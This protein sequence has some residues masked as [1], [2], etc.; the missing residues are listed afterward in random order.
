MTLRRFLFGLAALSVGVLLGLP[1]AA[2]LRPDAPPRSTE[3]ITPASVPL[4]AA[5]VE[6][7]GTD[8]PIEPVADVPD[9]ISLNRLLREVA[10]RVTPAVVFLRVDVTTTTAALEGFQDEFSPYYGARNTTGSGIIIS[11]SGYV[12]TNAHVVEGATRVRVALYDKR[13]YEAEIQGIDASTDLAVLRLLGVGADG[14]TEP[15]PVAT[16]GDSDAVAPGD[17]VLTVGSPL[18]LSNTVTFGIVS[19]T[20]RRIYEFEGSGGQFQIQDF[21][22]TDAAINPG[23]SG[24]ALVNVRG[25]VVG[26]VTSIATE[27]GFNEGYGFAVPSNLARRVAQ[28]LVSTG[29]VRRGFL[30]VEVQE[31][32][33]DVARTQGMRRAQGVQI[34]SVF[35]G[36]SGARAGLRAGDVLLAVDGRPV[37]SSNEFQSRL[38]LRRPGETVTLTVWR[39]GETETVRAALISQDDPSFR[40]WIAGREAP[41]PAG[42]EPPAAVPPDVP[43][44]EAVDWGIRF[45]DLTSRERRDFR[46]ASGAFVE[47]VRPESGAFVDGLPEGVVVTEIEGRAVNSAEDARAALARQARRERPALLRVRRPDGLTAFYDLASPFA[48]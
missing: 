28:D 10:A 1:V 5:D 4:D 39:E 23:S 7:G 44:S 35:S 13:E 24:G 27:S 20:G 31:V 47:A 11:R 30:G 41:L 33:H 16:F 3:T 40:T 22:Q 25:E 29:Q 12:L 42:P 17:F 2:W 36:G 18:R 19:A 38:A 8:A 14:D 32:T 34:V 45:R 9:L 21:I 46:V 43:R 37:D 26:I 6:I 48:E 15:L